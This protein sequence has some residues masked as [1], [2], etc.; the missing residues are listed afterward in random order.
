[1]RSS[2]VTRPLPSASDGTSG[3]LF[4]PTFRASCSTGPEPICCCTNTAAALLDSSSAARSVSDSGMFARWSR[5]I[6][7]PSGAAT[8]TSRRPPT[9]DTGDSP[10]SNAAA[11][12]KGLKAEP[13]CRRLRVALLNGVAA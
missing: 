8:A 1:M 11:Y 3:W 7:T 6:H 9:T 4:T 5:G 10:L 13:G 12:T 2:G